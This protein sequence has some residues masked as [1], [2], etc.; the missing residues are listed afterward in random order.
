MLRQ[1]EIPSTSVQMASLGCFLIFQ[2]PLLEDVAVLH[3]AGYGSLAI[4]EQIVSLLQIL[5]GIPR[6][7]AY[8]A[9]VNVGVGEW[10]K[11]NGRTHGEM[12]KYDWLCSV[13][14]GFAEN[15]HAPND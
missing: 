5:V 10:L 8:P 2:K 9:T 11:H 14:M 6:T 4:D 1:A 15:Q 3:H 13:S 12:T 7:L